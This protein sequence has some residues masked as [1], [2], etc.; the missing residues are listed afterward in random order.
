V[1]SRTR[2]LR[3]FELANHLGNVQVVVSDR[4]VQKDDNADGL[5]DYYVADIVS[6]T[7]YYA[8]GMVCLIRRL[9]QVRIASASMAK[10][11]IMK[12]KVQAINRI[13]G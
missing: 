9:V 10:K 3:K 2:G 8:F 5:I 11:M 13:M 7:D 12:S 1:F 4:K 6:A